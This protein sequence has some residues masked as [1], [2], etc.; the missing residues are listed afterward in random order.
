MRAFAGRGQQPFLTIAHLA[1]LTHNLHLNAGHADRPL[2]HLLGNIF[3]ERL[4]TNTVIIVFSDHGI[5]FG[6]LRR[7]ASGSF[8]ERL[9]FAYIYVP[10][11]QQIAGLEPG[12]VRQVLAG[13]S[14]RLTC[15]FDLHATMLHLLNGR[16]P[17]GEPFGRSWLTSIDNN[18]S[19]EAAGIAPNWCLCSGYV[20]LAADSA[21]GHQLGQLV[22]DNIN[23]QLAEHSTRCAPMSLAKVEQL[24]VDKF[25]T[26]TD[27]AHGAREK[28]MFVVRARMSPGGGLVEATL[29]TLWTPVEG[30]D[31][32]LQAEQIDSHR[33]EQFGTPEAI[34]VVGDI[35]RLDRYGPQ[36]W[37][38]HNAIVE[39]FCYCNRSPNSL[40]AMK[41]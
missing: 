22:V 40:E 9:P 8:E 39:K 10:E 2:E 1:D 6:R 11:N 18:R 37:C 16:E 17:Q 23:Q 41:L 4:N 3:A 19:C 14:H 35:S 30:G 24:K 27:T 36:A 33:G 34:E 21:L 20:S 12:Q 5:R 31:R 7:T 26:T 32:R 38:I 29:Q 25:G 13:N 15:H 28:R